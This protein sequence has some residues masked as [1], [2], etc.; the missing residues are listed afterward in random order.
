MN[1]LLD[2]EVGTHYFRA[3]ND[4]NFF[5]LRIEALKKSFF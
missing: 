2:H 4:G 1:C 3:L 5:D